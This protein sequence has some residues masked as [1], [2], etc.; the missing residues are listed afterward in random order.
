V[1]EEIV[2]EVGGFGVPLA[3]LRE[4]SGERELGSA[5]CEGEQQR[6]QPL[7]VASREITCALRIGDGFD[8]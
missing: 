8:E 1:V 7:R 6:G 4:V 5:M 3:P 2:Y